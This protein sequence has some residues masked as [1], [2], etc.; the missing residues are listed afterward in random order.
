[1]R[2]F[3]P[4]MIFIAWCYSANGDVSLALRGAG[5]FSQAIMKSDLR[6]ITGKSDAKLD[7]TQIKFLK[8]MRRDVV[9]HVCLGGSSGTGKSLMGA[10]TIKTKAAWLRRMYPSANIQIYVLSMIANNVEDELF[11]VWR[12]KYF[13]GLD[14]FEIMYRPPQQLCE[15]LGVKYDKL[16]D[17]K[18]DKLGAVKSICQAAEKA[19]TEKENKN[20]RKSFTLFLFDEISIDPTEDK[21]VCDYTGLGDLDSLATVT[22]VTC[23]RPTAGGVAAED[24]SF[25][26]PG[27]RSTQS[28]PSFCSRVLTVTYRNTQDIRNFINF[29]ADHHQRYPVISRSNDSPGQHLP[30]GPADRHAVTWIQ[31]SGEEDMGEA[32]RK[33]VQDRGTHNA[34]VL[35]TGESK[36]AAQA[37]GAHKIC[38]VKYFCGAEAKCVVLIN[39][40]SLSPED[41]S[42]AREELVIVTGP[43]LMRDYQQVLNLAAQPGHSH[44]GQVG[45]K[46]KWVKCKEDPCPWT[47]FP[48][49]QHKMV[50][51]KQGC[52]NIF[53]RKEGK[54]GK[55]GEQL[56]ICP[57][58]GCGC[59]METNQQKCRL[60]VEEEE[61]E[62]GETESEEDESSQKEEMLL[63]VIKTH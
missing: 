35:Y 30:P 27:T 43:L 51:T 45:E 2:C 61:S 20:Q 53:E 25:K 37:T 22:T 36:K 23:I 39:N 12:E 3:N 31:C 34:V 60:C 48:L 42:R 44:T 63:G 55:C 47:Q 46:V 15:E 40:Y 18:Y 49:L 9:R 29:V 4:T 6:S 58:Q 16:G 54:C 52:S 8:K 38:T 10:E 17:V 57:T 7:T 13:C 59:I 33:V 62:D 19:N 32:A 56:V 24:L 14:A 28:L 41:M 1:V 21:K 11:E 5:V 50:C 26:L